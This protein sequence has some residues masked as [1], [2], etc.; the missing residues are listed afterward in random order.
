MAG[1][2]G[3]ML[4]TEHNIDGNQYYVPVQPADLRIV[5]VGKT[6][7]GKSSSGNTILEREAFDCHLSPKSVT[8]E[9]WIEESVLQSKTISV[10]D[11]PGVYDTE[12]TE[13]KL[14]RALHSCI[15]MTVPGPHVFLLVIR[16]GVRY[17][18]EE[19]DAVKWI[20]DHFGKEALAYTLILFTHNDMLRGN[21][22]EQYIDES[23][24]L[25]ELITDCGGRFHGFNNLDTRRSQVT[26]LLQKIENMMEI[27]KGKGSEHYTNDM[28]K[29]AKRQ[30]E[31]ERLKN[32]AVGVAGAIV[33]VGTGGVLSSCKIA[34]TQGQYRWRC[35]SWRR[36]W[37]ERLLQP[38][39]QPIHFVR[40]G[41]GAPN[42]TQPQRS[43]LSGSSEWNLRVDLDRQLRFPKVPR[44]H[45]RMQRGW[46]VSCKLTGGGQAVGGASTEC[47]L[48]NMGVTGP[49]LR[50]ALKD[51]AE[52]AEQG[53]FWL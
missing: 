17:N 20:C 14:T 30:I 23:R 42:I 29:K 7:S 41:G 53:S 9:S 44:P 51:L 35:R 1:K 18:K 27:N 46:M 49:K 33:V 37:R 26:A 10:T 38:S 11:T 34:L 3:P 32:V 13:E 22:L 47:F 21:H 50:E 5:L 52:E 19:K 43:A 48:K 45:S 24:E 31:L 36:S 4:K 40:E 39:C 15:Y 12:F 2:R 6:G 8:K 25:K 16:V 28:F